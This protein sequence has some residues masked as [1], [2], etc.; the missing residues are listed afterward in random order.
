MSQRISSDRVLLPTAEACKVSGFSR[1]YIAR[2]LR[3][4]R[5][6]GVK[7]GHDWLVYEDSLT[8]FLAQPRKR[9]P[10]GPRK[11]STQ[12]HLDPLSTDTSRDHEPN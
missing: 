11:K 1:E 6:E 2:L 4:R 7:L 8:T 12:D 5:I 9:G 10:K 3:E